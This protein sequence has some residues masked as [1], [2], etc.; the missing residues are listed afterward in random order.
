MGTANSDAPDLA[1]ITVNYRAAPDTIECLKS[2]LDS[3][4][5]ARVVVVD[6]NSA[7]GSVEQ[8]EAW[9]GSQ[10]LLVGDFEKRSGKRT[11]QRLSKR[12]TLIASKINGGFASGNNIGLKAAL[13]TEEIEIFWLLNNDTVVA[14][15]AAEEA[16]R[17][18]RAN[19]QVGM[20]GTQL[21]LYHDPERFQLLN[22]MEFSLL[23]GAASGIYSG[24]SV[25]TSFDPEDVLSRTDF[26]CGASLLMRRNF[27]HAVGLLEESFFLYYE[28]VDLAFRGKAFEVG[29]VADAIVYH[30]EGATAGSASQLSNRARSPLSEYHH[31]RSKMIFAKKHAPAFLPIY[32]I[33]NL[34]IWLRRIWRNQPAQAGAVW[35]AT[36]GLPFRG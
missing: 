1:I 13:A 25:Q 31:I 10:P 23:T 36:M 26:I 19:P 2:L 15:G 22:G 4:T 9:L 5:N 8:I 6:N 21:R 16:I 12:I 7:D 20:A 29:F 34:A 32:F 35:R 33:Q 30:K 3:R 24:R 17:Y 28:E 14:Q 11:D 18:F 27:L